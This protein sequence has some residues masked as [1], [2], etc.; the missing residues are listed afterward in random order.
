MALLCIVLLQKLNS[1]FRNPVDH[2]LPYPLQ[3]HISK[4]G[5]H[6]CYLTFL[7]TALF[8]MF[9]YITIH[10]HLIASLSASCFLLGGGGSFCGTERCR[11]V[12][13]L[14]YLLCGSLGC[15][16][17]LFGMPRLLVHRFLESLHL[18]EVE[19]QF[20]NKMVQMVVKNCQGRGREG[21]EGGFL[22]L[23]NSVG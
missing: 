18:G 3:H 19:I 2:S 6:V 15:C 20:D 4:E 14:R 23:T 12:G 17:W 9:L 22:H 7:L 11:W 16:G 13:M 21:G 10:L 1:S 5:L 8:Y